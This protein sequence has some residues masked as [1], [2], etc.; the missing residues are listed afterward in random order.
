MNSSDKK[1]NFWIS[2]YLLSLFIRKCLAVLKSILS[3]IAFVPVPFQIYL[4][5]ILFLSNFKFGVSACG[6]ENNLPKWCIFESSHF[7][8]S[9][10]LTFSKN[11]YNFWYTQLYE[12]R[13]T[14]L[15]ITQ[16]YW[17][18]V[19]DRSTIFS[20]ISPLSKNIPKSYPLKI[21]LVW[22]AIESFFEAIDL[23]LAIIIDYFLQLFPCI[24]HPLFL[25]CLMC[26][27]RPSYEISYRFRCSI[28]ETLQ[29]QSIFLGF[30]LR[31]SQRSRTMLPPSEH[32][33]RLLTPHN[34]GATPV[35][36]YPENVGGIF[37]WFQKKIFLICYLFQKWK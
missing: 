37:F 4:F 16:F 6:R 2:L 10:H 18:T 8:L 19:I 5:S 25:I 3:L 30:R 33:R 28:F 21:D 20:S 34:P 7:Y 11:T 14:L 31:I 13:Y 29:F 32:E 36:N 23:W 27:S 35:N 15:L 12:L 26:V 24:Y 17:C 1:M 9:A 22:L